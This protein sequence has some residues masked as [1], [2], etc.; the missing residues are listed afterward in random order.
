MTGF[1]IKVELE[2]IPSDKELENMTQDQCRDLC[3]QNNWFL[4]MD[5]NGVKVDPKEW[6]KCVREYASKPFPT[7]ED[8]DEMDEEKMRLFSFIKGWIYPWEINYFCLSYKVKF[9]PRTY[10]DEIMKEFDDGNGNIDK[11][12]LNDILNND[13][14]ARLAFIERVLRNGPKA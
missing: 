6:I 12:R 10:L 5:K 14:E 1:N 13:H 7:M 3:L 4:P 9:D 8:L 2:N 11:E